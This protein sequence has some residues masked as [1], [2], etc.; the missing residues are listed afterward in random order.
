MKKI[1]ILTYHACFNY[2]ACLQAYA[3]QQSI[4]KIQPDCEIID[5]QS[6]TLRNI[7]DVFSKRPDNKKEVI[8]NI[9]RLPYKKQLDR[10]QKMF[11]DFIN[12]ELIISKRCT[13]ESD[14]EKQAEEYECIVCGSDQTWNLEPSIRYCNEV[15]Y[16][17]FTKKQRRVT[18]ATSFGQW[19]EKI[20][21]REA[22][23]LPWI[24]EFDMLSM[25]EESGVSYLRSKGF[26]CEHVLDPTL[27]L[28]AEEYN[29]ICEMPDLDKPYVLMFSWNCAKEVINVAK[30]AAKQLN[31]EVINIVAPPRALFSGVPRKL[32]VGPKQFLGLVKNAEFVVTNSFHGTVFSSLYNKQ[33]ASVISGSVDK[34]RQSLMKQ[35]GLENNLIKPEEFNLSEIA[36]TDFDIVNKNIEN[37]KKGSLEYLSKAIVF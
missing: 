19:V 3:L 12:N 11:E 6:T 32:D 21:D 34:R 29:K 24:K 35:L 4:M 27:L 1:G 22:D 28:N 30:E 16:L 7:C 18:Y 25:R 13:T 15:Y 17:N 2:G 5:Y 33:F 14:V 9:T 10:R 36:K 37:I 31:C 26:E 8:K 20:S 23:I